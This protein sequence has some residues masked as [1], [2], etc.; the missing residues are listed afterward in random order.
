MQS[1]T[2][3]GT[4]FAYNQIRSVS[5]QQNEFPKNQALQFCMPIQT[6]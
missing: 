6:S 5:L 1:P 3:Q 4:M 2:F